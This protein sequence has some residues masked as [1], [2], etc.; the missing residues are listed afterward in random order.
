MTC[1]RRLFEWQSQLFHSRI[2]LDTYW[3]DESAI[4]IDILNEAFFMNNNIFPYFQSTNVH[5]GLSKFCLQFFI[6]NLQVLR[7]I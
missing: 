6:I 1:R 7:I 2:N 4:L 5:H 3:G